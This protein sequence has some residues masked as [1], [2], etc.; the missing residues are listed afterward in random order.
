MVRQIEELGFDFVAFS[1]HHFHV[2]GLEVSNN[3][4][5]LG[6]WAAMLTTRL[7]IA[8]M[9][10]VL[11]SRNPVL[12]AEDL[13]ML[14][15]FSGGRMIAG[16]A[17]GY[18]VRHVATIGQK[19]NAYP[20]AA[21]DPEF[22]AHDRINR[23]LFNAHYAIIRKAWTEPLF[24]HQGRH[25]QIPPPNVAWNHPATRA[26]AG[27]MIDDDGMLQ[28]VG[29][30]PLT[31][32]DPAHIETFIPF[33][34]SAETIEWSAHQGVKPVIF[35]PIEEHAK[36]SIDLFHRACQAAGRNV[37]WGRELGHFRDSVIEDTEAEAIAI[38]ESGMGYIW[39]R[40]HDW[41]GFNE[42]LRCPGEQGAIPNTPRSVRERGLRTR[43][44]RRFRRA[45]ARK[46]G[47][48]PQHGSRRAVDRGG[49]GADRQAAEEQRT[50]G[51]ESAAEDRIDAQPG[52]ATAARR[53][54]RADVAGHAGQS[55]MTSTSWWCP[56][57]RHGA[58]GRRGGTP[59]KPLRSLLF[60]PAHREKWVAK[61]PEFGAD[62]VIL[63]FEDS[64]PRNLKPA[65]RRIAADAIPGLA[66]AGQR[67][68]VRVNPTPY[69]YD[70]DDL[71]AVVQSGCE[72]LVLSKTS[73][74][75]GVAT[76]DALV[77]EIELRAGM[78]V[79]HTQFLPVLESARAIQLA[80]E[81]AQQAR[82][83]TLR[84]ASAR[85]GDV[86]RALGFEWTAD[87]LESLY[88][89]S[90]AVLAVRAAGK[91]N[92]LAGLWQDVHDLDGLRHYCQFHCQLGFKGEMIL[93]PSNVAVVNEVFMP[94]AA[95]LAYYRGMVEAFETA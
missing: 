93:H 1:E 74:P 27:G 69:L 83:A 89:K 86:A 52:H 65:A 85:N 67:L 95:E 16:F 91:G 20:T 49:S 92:P 81:I 17:R 53:I 63:D 76:L 61:I 14:D 45:P 68:Y 23:E 48:H 44:H 7:R 29:I 15:P 35:T 66:A 2:E 64:V 11:P 42:A 80:F 40:W 94:S 34:I 28:R 50:A 84:M 32:Q 62:A 26:L 70:L 75:E 12:L 19:L 37:E 31:L 22:E 33:T 58:R 72:G 30:A 10:I 25:W 5:M 56:G 79:G 43:R 4:V 3:P 90:R 82:V 9:G 77:S 18:Q 41:F 54:P 46:N 71:Q 59:M 36:A 21:T 87:G 8:Q 78:T 47:E 51:G 24:S 6:A 13:A 38:Q 88:L 55:R 73:G 60:V 57:R 39:T